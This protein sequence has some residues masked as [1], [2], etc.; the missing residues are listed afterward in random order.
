MRPHNASRP[1]HWT[2]RSS[3]RSQRGLYQISLRGHPTRQRPAAQNGNPR[4]SLVGQVHPARDKAS[5]SV[6]RTR[7]DGTRWS[8]RDR[9]PTIE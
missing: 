4:T 7:T 2:L 9:C 6:G 8:D 1:R 5:R 3:V